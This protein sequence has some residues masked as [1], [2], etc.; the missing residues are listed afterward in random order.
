MPRTS[1]RT[2]SA[3]SFCSGTVE[4]LGERV[5]PHGLI[6]LYR[7]RAA[8]HDER[9]AEPA[10][11]VVFEFHG[12][13]RRTDAPYDL[14]WSRRVLAVLRDPDRLKAAVKRRLGL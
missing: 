4:T 6:S 2:T 5:G 12:R 9:R 11:Y 10:K 14:P 1:M 7:R 3:S 8:R 13:H